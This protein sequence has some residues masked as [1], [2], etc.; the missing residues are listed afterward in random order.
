MKL[1]KDILLISKKRKLNLE[2]VYSKCQTIVSDLTDLQNKEDQIQESYLY[3]DGYGDYEVWHDESDEEKDNFSQEEIDSYYQEYARLKAIEAE[4]QELDT[5]IK[6]ELTFIDEFNENIKE[7]SLSTLTLSLTLDDTEGL[8]IDKMTA[9]ERKNLLTTAIDKY[10]A[11]FDE[12]KNSLLSNQQDGLVSVLNALGYP[13]DLSID[14]PFNYQSFKTLYTFINTKVVGDKTPVDVINDY[15]NGQSWEESGM[16]SLAVQLGEDNG[17]KV[18]NATDIDYE[19][20]FWRNMLY[21][22]DG[23]ETNNYT[24]YFMMS[25]DYYKEYGGD[26]SDVYNSLFIDKLI[27]EDDP[28]YEYY[29][30]PESYYSSGEYTEYRQKYLNLALIDSLKSEFKKEGYL[31]GLNDYVAEINQ[32][33]DEYGEA[34]PFI[35]ALDGRMDWTDN[36][37]VIP[38]DVIVDYINGK[39][40]EESGLSRFCS[41]TEEEFLNDYMDLYG[42][43]YEFYRYTDEEWNNN[44]ADT[45]DSSYF[46][47]NKNKTTSFLPTDADTSTYTTESIKELIKSRGVADQV[48]DYYSHVNERNDQI[49]KE[50]TELYAISTSIRTLKDELVEYEPPTEADLLREQNK[51]EGKKMA[52]TYLDAIKDLSGKDEYVKT[53][54]QDE[55]VKLKQE[56][57]PTLTREEILKE[58]TDAWKTEYSTSLINNNNYN[59]E[60]ARIMAENADYSKKTVVVCDDLDA[61]STVYYTGREVLSDVAVAGTGLVS[62]GIDLGR[63][64]KHVVAPD[65]VPTALQYAQDEIAIQY[66]DPSSEYYDPVKGSI[67]SVTRTIGHDGTIQVLKAIPATNKAGEVLEFLDNYGQNVQTAYEKTGGNIVAAEAN[68]AGKAGV[69]LLAG[70]VNLGGDSYLEKAVTA[71][72]KSEVSNYGNNTVDYVTGVKTRDEATASIEKGHI[73]AL[74]STVMAGLPS[75]GSV[76]GNDTVDKYINAVGTNEAKTLVNGMLTGDMSSFASSQGDILVSSGID[77]TAEVVKDKVKSAVDTYN[78]VK[79]A[80][81]GRLYMDG[82]DF[83]VANLSGN[84][85]ETVDISTHKSDTPTLN[86]SY[87]ASSAAKDVKTTLNGVVDAVETASQQQTTD[88]GASYGLYVPDSQKE[89]VGNVNNK[90]SAMTLTNNI[91]KGLQFGYS[92]VMTS[93]N[94]ETVSH[95]SHP[96]YEAQRFMKEVSR[97]EANQEVPKSIFDTPSNNEENTSIKTDGAVI[98][99]YKPPSNIDNEQKKYTGANNYPDNNL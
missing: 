48:G 86:S 54:T 42:T 22:I 64:I 90:V 45:Q 1:F 97:Y 82:D 27:D 43:E 36:N 65:L 11:L 8:D 4:C 62:G 35:E 3:N 61:L 87:I 88:E 76:T 85:D 28:N 20:E 95:D 69:K 98:S 26:T 93:S 53:Y 70:S 78:L 29:T 73:S 91:E 89:I 77:A 81:S 37:S 83:K 41:K 51:A 23:R 32:I 6:G 84:P 71:G 40:W 79:D 25:S 14:G 30:D 19:A 75:S 92:N 38:K 46:T 66:N 99:G 59:P 33:N 5:K 13:Y 55:Y 80:E 47:F 49:E 17:N 74:T 72:V 15:F 24:P 16:A 60:C 18:K 7:F 63:N 94:N 50:S 10:E 44:L 21:E 2:T 56:E 31:Q 68:A 39:S 96:S 67:Y 9:E 58:Y 57:D 34:L 52:E 12:K